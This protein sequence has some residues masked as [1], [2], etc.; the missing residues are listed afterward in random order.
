MLPFGCLVLKLDLVE[1]QGEE[2]VE[3][4]FDVDH[5]TNGWFNGVGETTGEK[6]FDPKLLNDVVLLP[7]PFHRVSRVDCFLSRNPSRGNGDCLYHSGRV[8][9][10][11]ER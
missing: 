9:F 10:C 11:R 3:F 5:R 4:S 8:S 6:V 7:V 2:A 1:A